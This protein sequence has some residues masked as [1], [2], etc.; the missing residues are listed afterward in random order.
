MAMVLIFILINNQCLFPFCIFFSPF[1]F[2]YTFTAFDKADFDVEIYRAYGGMRVT[3]AK[4]SRTKFRK[5]QKISKFFVNLVL[6]KFTMTSFFG[7]NN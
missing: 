3:H 5:N 2:L 6:T 1:F 4:T 7:I